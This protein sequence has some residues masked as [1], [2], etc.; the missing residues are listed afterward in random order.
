MNTKNLLSY[1]LHYMLSYVLSTIN[2]KEWENY[3]RDLLTETG[4]D[5]KNINYTAC[6]EENCDNIQ[7]ITME[8]FN[9][10]LKVKKK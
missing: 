9:Q 5:F 8:E 10:A 2:I 4:D 7:E 1:L 6:N 3:F